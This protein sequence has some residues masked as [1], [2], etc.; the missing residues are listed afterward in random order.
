MTVEQAIGVV[1]AV[2]RTPLPMLLEMPIAS[3]LAWLT[4]VPVV[5]PLVEPFAGGMKPAQKSSSI[6]Q[7]MQIA[8]LT[9]IPVIG[10]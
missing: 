2:Y 9:G 1:A 8:Q 6:E 4:D 10:G 3:I 7:L 5:L